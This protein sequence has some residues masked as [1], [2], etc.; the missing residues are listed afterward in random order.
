MRKVHFEDEGKKRREGQENVDELTRKLLRLNMKDNTY[1]VAY[2]QLFVLAPEMTDNLPP[3]SR[4]GASTIAATNSVGAPT[5][6][7]HPQ[8]QP[9]IPMPPHF[10][11]H[12]CKKPECY[13]RTCPTA[14]EYVWSEQAI[15]QPNGYYAHPDGL[16]IDAHHPEGLKGAIDAK[17]KGRNMLSHLT[18]TTATFTKFSSFIEAAQ[19]EENEFVWGAIAELE[20]E[21]EEVGG[22]TITRAQ[23][24]KEGMKGANKKRETGNSGIGK[25][26]KRKAEEMRQPAYQQE[27]R[28][29][30][31]ETPQ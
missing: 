19:E 3:P 10:S 18:R 5:Y 20:K 29:A 26:M 9:S 30:N 23:S 17:N 4:F 12:F 1:A 22:L 6:P 2:A 21:K 14:A 31:S 16:L 25:E 15:L 8:S 27:P 24:Q 28:I 13:L 7:R 11:C